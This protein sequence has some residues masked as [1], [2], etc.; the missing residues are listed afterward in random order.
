MTALHHDAVLQR[1]LQHDISA[2][3]PWNDTIASILNHRSVR[4]YLDTPLPRGLV[5]VLVASAQSAATSSNLQAWSVLTVEDPERK[6]RLATLAGD[7]AHIR[8]APLFMVWL[9]DLSRIKRQADTAETD[10]EPTLDSWLIGSIDAAL[11]AQN[12][13][14]ALESLGLGSVYIGGLRNNLTEIIELLNLPPLVFPVFGLCVGFPN[15]DKVAS[16]K[17]RLPQQVVVHKERYESAYEQDHIQRY[18]SGVSQLSR[19]QGVTAPHWSKK[20][21]AT[22]QSVNTAHRRE[23]I[24][25]V[26][27]AQLFWVH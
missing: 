26:L 13:V 15:P 19:A 9:A 24:V 27:K 6:D 20:A 23:E 2:A 21:I 10:I 7:Q 4:A 8:Q 18:D 22:L 1:Y 5:E 14:I 16:I 25:R 12:A 3:I 11:A 17:P